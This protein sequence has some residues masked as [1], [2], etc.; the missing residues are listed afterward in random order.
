MPASLPSY[1]DLDRL[2]IERGHTN[3]RI[4]RS[5][6]GRRWNVFCDCGY[7]EADPAPKRRSWATQVT[8]T[9][10]LINHV[11]KDVNTEVQNQARNGHKFT[12]SA[13]VSRPDP[14]G[15]D[16]YGSDNVTGEGHDPQA[17]SVPG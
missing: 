8:A 15:P 13:R 11:R 3:M 10:A 14:V 16:L 5:A 9:A 17:R 2:A 6:S 4:E 12:R 1:G 7:G